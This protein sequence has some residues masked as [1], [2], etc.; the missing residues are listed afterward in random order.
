MEKFENLSKE[1]KCF[2]IT[3][4]MVAVMIAIAGADSIGE[5][6]FF[7]AIIDLLNCAFIGCI[8]G[9]ITTI[10]YMIVSAIAPKKTEKLISYLTKEP[11]NDY[12]DDE[13]D[14]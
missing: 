4:G 9:A 6:S 5:H 3:S 13:V 2:F 1:V 14:E 12:F 7:Q 11:E 8:V 10:I